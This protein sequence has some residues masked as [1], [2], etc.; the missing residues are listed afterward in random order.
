MPESPLLRLSL[1]MH[2]VRMGDLDGRLRALVAAA[3]EGDDVAVRGFVRLTQPSVWRLC[4]LLGSPD[5]VEDLTQDTYIRAL[6]SMPNYRGDSQVIGWLLS[7]ARH[8]CA[9]HVR[10]RRRQRRLVDTLSVGATS[11][12]SNEPDHAIWDI[13]REI[14]PDRREAFVLT[15]VAGLS[16]EEAAVILD[17]PLGTVRSRVARARSDLAAAVRASQAC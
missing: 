10:V 6:R 3:I 17:C 12:V 4:S 8:V 2:D 11:A 7:I 15:Q 1:M 9:D 5:D 14:D 13:V 16:Y